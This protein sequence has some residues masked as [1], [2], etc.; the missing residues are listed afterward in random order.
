MTKTRL[1][2][3][4]TSVELPSD[5]IGK[6]KFTKLRSRSSRE[7][8][9]GDYIGEIPSPRITSSGIH[10]RGAQ[11]SCTDANR[12]PAEPI[13]DFVPSQSG[14]HASRPLIPAHA[15]PRVTARTST[16]ANVHFVR[17]SLEDRIGTIANRW[18]SLRTPS[19]MSLVV[20]ALL[21]N[22]TNTDAPH[23][24]GRPGLRGSKKTTLR[25]RLGCLP[26][27]RLVCT[28]G[29]GRLEIRGNPPTNE[30]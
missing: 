12:E 2:A 13:I 23:E 16:S 10:T 24:A 25:R 15:G 22:R 7:R 19:R 14:F 4:P 11:S 3:E 27:V 26:R 28:R 8:P 21:N 17:L 6:S 9:S 18:Q 20:A 29:T 30:E 1:V 5:L